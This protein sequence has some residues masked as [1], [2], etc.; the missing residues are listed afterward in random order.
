MYPF[1]DDKTTRSQL[2]IIL[3]FIFLK[4]GWLI[5]SYT[6]YQDGILY[7]LMPQYLTKTNANLKMYMH[8]ENTDLDL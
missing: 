2:V 4:D 3:F 5:L 1:E 7:L 6:E 8:L